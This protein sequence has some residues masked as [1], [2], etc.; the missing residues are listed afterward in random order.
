MNNRASLNQG[1]KRRWADGLVPP[2][3]APCAYAFPTRTRQ[4]PRG[5]PAH[6]GPAHPLSSGL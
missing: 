6:R 2:G 4:G 3:Q 1:A 5:A